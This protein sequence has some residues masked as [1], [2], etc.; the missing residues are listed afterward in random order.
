MTQKYDYIIAGAGAAGLSLVMHLLEQNI[1]A[2]ISILIIDNDNKKNNDRTWCFWQKE[3]SMY[4][5]IVYKKWDKLKAFGVDF[6]KEENIAPYTYKMIRGID[7]YNYCFDKIKAH[8]NIDVIKATIK[9]ITSTT[10]YATVVADGVEYTATYVFS[11]ILLQQP[12]L[13]ASNNYLLQHFKGQV[14]E[15][16]EPVFKPDVA[17]YMDFR[18]SQQHGCTFGYVLPFTTN[19]ALVE[20]T[21]FTANT[22]TTEQYNEGLQNYIK[23]F[24]KI[25]KYKVVEEE[26]GI[27]PMTDYKFKKTDANII[28]LGTAGGNT[29]GSTGYTFSYIQKHSKALATSLKYGKHPNSIKNTISKNAKFYDSVFLEVLAKGTVQ[30]KDLFSRILKHKKL[31]TLLSFLDDENNFSNDIKIMWSQPKLPFIKAAIKKL[32]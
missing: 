3:Q 29:R 14:I 9:S 5:S 28:Y 30:G 1:P 26:Q 11:S 10:S 19:K 8:S 18:V 4:E 16:A 27:I 22:L 31:T 7:F 13:K 25:N 17:T 20:Y 15:T 21:L 24:L 32:F 12:Q 2:S 23:E 6:E